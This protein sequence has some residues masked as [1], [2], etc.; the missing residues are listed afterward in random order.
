[1]D[2]TSSSKD[3]EKR[4]LPGEENFRLISAIAETLLSSTDPEAAVASIGLRVMDHLDCQA[5]FNFMADENAGRLRLNACSGIPEEEIGKIQWLDYGA[6]VCGSVAREGRRII[7]DHI[8]STV[9]ERTELVKSYGIRAYACHPLLARNDDV[10]GTLS[11]GTSTRDTFSEHDLSFMKTV[12]DL[13]AEAVARAKAEQALKDREQEL[14]RAVGMLRHHMENSPLAFVGFDP[15]Y[16]VIRWSTK[17]RDMFGWTAGEILGK[18]ITDIRWVHE[19]DAERVA[20][21]SADMFHGRKTT[22]THIN[23]NYRKDGSLIVCEWHNS[24]LLDNHGD[25]LSIFSFV[26]DITEQK[27]LEADLSISEQRFHKAF[28]YASIGKALV[29]PEGSWLRV[30]RAV[31]ELLGYTEEELLALTFQDITHPDDLDADLSY[32]EQ[33]LSGDIKTYQMEKRYFH[34]DGHIVWVLLSVSLVRDD[35]DRP[36]YFIS[37]IE[38]ITERKAAEEALVT[39]LRE[40]ELLLKEIH[41]RV[42][43]NLMVVSSILNLQSGTIRDVK[44]KELLDDCRKR[45]HVMSMIHNKLYRST[46][47]ARINFREYGQE[48]L[49]DISRSYNL[50]AAAIDLSVAMD[51]IQF[52]IDTAIPLGLILNELYSN[53]MKYAFPDDREGTVMIGLKRTGDEITFIVRDNGIGFPEDI[54]F[55]RTETLGMQL[56]VS[57]VEQLEGTI[58][59][60][61]DGGTEFRM[62]F[63]YES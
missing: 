32:V 26:H 52:S 6:A 58:E 46:D 56:V 10:I 19:D 29:S 13:I 31:C 12:S 30:N 15:E 62:T 51:D 54:D 20:A 34:K 18:K 50:H 7:A 22:N 37:Q 27:K 60:S 61:R 40:K 44:A 4:L 24:V 47:L 17:A 16:R 59:M 45:I 3:S 53:S 8:C 55:T 14:T 5:F 38:D 33:M 23:R 21:L 28:E 43:N 48:L 63:P 42:K 49:A 11:F 35:A 9:D 41:H 36:A 25:L 57:L 1:M 2:D 39:S